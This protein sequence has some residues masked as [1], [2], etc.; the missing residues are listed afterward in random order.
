MIS[1]SS[2]GLSLRAKCFIYNAITWQIVFSY[3]WLSQKHMLLNLNK[4][5]FM[6]ILS[7][8]TIIIQTKTIFLIYHTISV[9]NGDQILLI[10]LLKWLVYYHEIFLIRSA[11]QCH[12]LFLKR[13]ISKKYISFII[14]IMLRKLL[15]TRPT[16]RHWVG[17]HL[18]LTW[19]RKRPSDERRSLMLIYPWFRFRERKRS[20]RLIFR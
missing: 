20:V 14:I 11:M 6:Q 7:T 9:V 1:S 5:T 13:E 12:W 8:C 4:A 3:R 19:H 15:S 2:G 17:I 18:L 16:P 10:I